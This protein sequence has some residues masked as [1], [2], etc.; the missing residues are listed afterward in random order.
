MGETGREEEQ[1]AKSPH[2]VS[3]SCSFVR[4]PALLF[5]LPLS[6]VF[7]SCVW[8]R[9][10]GCSRPAG[11]L[12][13]KVRRDFFFLFFLGARVCSCCCCCFCRGCSTC[14]GLLAQL[15]SVCVPMSTASTCIGGRCGEP[16]G[17]GG[18]SVP[19]A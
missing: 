9:R 19:Q 1:D 10:G 11:R 16:C 7:V 13:E 15:F 8:R 5:S 3:E 6:S 4:Y 12:V 17:V 18:K 14:Q 2:W